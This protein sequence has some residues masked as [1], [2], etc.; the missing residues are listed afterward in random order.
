MTMPSDD[1]MTE[2][3][4]PIRRMEVFTGAGRRRAWSDEE[5][6]RIV[7]ESYSGAE[8]VC[9]VARR[10]GLVPTQLFT[11]RREA[12]TQA[13]VDSPADRLFTPVMIESA[14]T[15]T[16]SRR[17]RTR[18]RPIERGAVI[19][20]ECDGVTV[21]VGRGAESSTV[22]AIIRALKSAR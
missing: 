1:A 20:L 13:V 22:A 16:R 4:S 14:G 11:W 19:E 3:G 12:R 15:P 2:V 5:K 18:N 8:T 17:K 9:A 7:A 21:R 6:T 10:H